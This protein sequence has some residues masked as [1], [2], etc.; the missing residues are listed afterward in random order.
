MP[1]ANQE[2]SCGIG[3][4]PAGVPGPRPRGGTREAGRPAGADRPRPVMHEIGVVQQVGG[5]HDLLAF[6]LGLV[7]QP[8]GQWR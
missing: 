7:Q 6:D 2:I 1:S 8:Y 5:L 3:L 4:A